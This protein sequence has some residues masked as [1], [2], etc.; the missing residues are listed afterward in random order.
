MLDGALNVLGYYEAGDDWIRSMKY[1]AEQIEEHRN[2]AEETQTIFAELALV[3]SQRQEAP[4]RIAN[5]IR[6]F[7]YGDDSRAEDLKTMLDSDD[8]A[9]R[10]IFERC[11]WRPTKEEAKREE[12]QRKKKK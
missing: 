4:L 8:P 3:T 5:C 11:Y 12:H 9:F 2:S 7:L 10:D 1:T 6:D